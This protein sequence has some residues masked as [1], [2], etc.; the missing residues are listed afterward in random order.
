MQLIINTFVSFHTSCNR[1][2]GSTSERLFTMLIASLLTRRSPSPAYAAEEPVIGNKPP[3]YS[4]FG[5]LTEKTRHR[6]AARYNRK[7]YTTLT[8]GPN[9]IILCA[10]QVC[11]F[12]CRR[13]PLTTRKFE[14]SE[15]VPRWEAIFSVEDGFKN[16]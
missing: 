2:S 4:V 1:W 16:I 3:M 5:L 11:V 6:F 14:T 9:C 8:D 13:F 10:C 12:N 15:R 7:K